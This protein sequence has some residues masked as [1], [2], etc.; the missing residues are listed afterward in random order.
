MA[1]EIRRHRTPQTKTTSTKPQSHPIARIAGRKWVRVERIAGFWGV[2]RET[3]GIDSFA[4]G[5]VTS[6]IATYNPAFTPAELRAHGR[7]LPS[8]TRKEKGMRNFTEAASQRP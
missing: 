1:M 4:K 3:T 6:S 2:T 5:W 8:P 7:W